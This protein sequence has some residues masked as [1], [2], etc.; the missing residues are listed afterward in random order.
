[1]EFK[2][3]RTDGANHAGRVASVGVQCSVFGV[4]EPMN[5][6]QGEPQELLPS[7]TPNSEH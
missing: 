1:V 3:K 6:E 4:A 7:R 5:G 2:G